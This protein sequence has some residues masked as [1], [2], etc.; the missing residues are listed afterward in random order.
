MKSNEIFCEPTVS[1]IMPVYNTSAYLKESIISVLA[2]NFTNFELI[3]VDDG[4]TDNSNIIVKNLLSVD[5]RLVY[6]HQNNQGLSSARNTGI[7]MAR[8]KYILFL[9]SDDYIS[10]E[11]LSTCLD[12]ASKFQSELVVFSGTNFSDG[13]LKESQFNKPFLKQDIYQSIPGEDLL[14]EL[15]KAGSYS[16]SACLYL[17]SLDLIRRNSLLFE[18]G[19]IHE[20]ISFSTKLYCYAISAIS[21]SNIFLNRRIH[22]NSITG[23]PKTKE[24]AFGLYRAAYSLEELKATNNS[25]KSTTLKIIKNY[26]R[27]LLRGAVNIAL[28]IGCHKEIILNI[29][30]SFP[31]SSLLRVDWLAIFY[32]SSI[33]LFY[34]ARACKRKYL[35]R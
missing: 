27:D 17:A 20:D 4:S 23:S 16:P 19:Y 7:S 18:E 15:F 11:T 24:H 6:I 13:A 35:N 33:R 21:T 3:V 30:N 32:I 29:K 2:Q 14:A 5:K 25:L 8:G 34:L 10:P 9:D 22:I 12:L 1:I 28:D 31:L 26:Q